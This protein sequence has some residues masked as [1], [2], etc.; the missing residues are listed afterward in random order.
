MAFSTWK[1]LGFIE[2]MHGV[3]GT[4]SGGRDM[5]NAVCRYSWLV[6]ERLGA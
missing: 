6:R 4:V 2:T 5:V 3:M 1:E